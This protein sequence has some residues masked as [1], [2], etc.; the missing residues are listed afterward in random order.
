MGV[1]MRL[2]TRIALVLFFF[3]IGAGTGYAWRSNIFV[4]SLENEESA[5]ILKKQ[6]A[7]K[8]DNLKSMMKDVVPAP[9]VDHDF[10][11]FDTL[12]DVDQGRFVDLDGTIVVN[13]DAQVTKVNGEEAVPGPATAGNSKGP[14]DQVPVV[15]A[16][17]TKTLE[18]RIKELEALLGEDPASSG[19]GSFKYDEVETP[20]VEPVESP[21]F[22][23]PA[24]REKISDG[25]TAG[26]RYQVQVSSFREI[27]R[28]RKLEAQLR[29]KGYN[30]FYTPV[31]IPGK[32]IW[33]RVFL[34]EF[35]AKGKAQEAASRA[36]QQDDLQTMILTVR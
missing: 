20:T 31:S 12:N 19:S 10:T 16:E 14:E 29:K 9:K 25:V 18:E 11:F 21:S 15:V 8:P 6:R 35:S 1:F 23:E 28:A 7:V 17:N 13:P 2:K 30:A 3:A 4:P 33:Y 26:P 32:G 36:R 22:E 27:E 24:G 34:G 5:H